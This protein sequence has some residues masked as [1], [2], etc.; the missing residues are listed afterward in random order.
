MNEHIQSSHKSKW[1]TEIILFGQSNPAVRGR[2]KA[3]F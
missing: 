3:S 2:G 1:N